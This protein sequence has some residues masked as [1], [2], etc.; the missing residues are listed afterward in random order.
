[1]EK[2]LTFESCTEEEM[3]VVTIKDKRVNQ[4]IHSYSCKESDGTCDSSPNTPDKKTSKKNAQRTD[5][6]KF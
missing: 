5:A 3:E 4:D 6:S 1:M 2:N